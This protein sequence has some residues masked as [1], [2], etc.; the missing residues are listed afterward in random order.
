MGKGG[1]VPDFRVSPP[2]PV[3]RLLGADNDETAWPSPYSQFASHCC[4]QTRWHKPS[5]VPY[6]QEIS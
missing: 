4:V 1:A 2:V 6:D 5:Q 3:E